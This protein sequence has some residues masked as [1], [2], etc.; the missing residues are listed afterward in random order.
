MV[1]LINQVSFLPSEKEKVAMLGNIQELI[2][3]RDIT[4]LATY[5]KDVIAFQ[6]DKNSDVRKWIVSF[7]EEAW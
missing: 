2:L 6:S 3:H 7:I 1:E 4:L 5:Y